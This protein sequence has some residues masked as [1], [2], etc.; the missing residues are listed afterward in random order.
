MR[1]L[2]TILME[3]VVCQTA[4]QIHHHNLQSA[5]T[6]RT[7]PRP[8]WSHSSLLRLVCPTGKH[9]LNYRYTYSE[10]LVTNHRK[11]E[12]NSTYMYIVHHKN[13]FKQL[14]RFKHTAKLYKD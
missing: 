14:K 11:L 4:V 2:L 1:I 12:V 9:T 8:D 3:L 5:E 7:S 6:G 10:R 13:V